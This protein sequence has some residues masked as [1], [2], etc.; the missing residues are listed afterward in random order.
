MKQGCNGILTAAILSAR[1]DRFHFG[2]RID[3]HYWKMR[4]S[5]WP[6]ILVCWQAGFNWEL[7]LI[8]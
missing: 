3:I 4:I 2:V 8:A 7:G 1:L 5:Q 6:I